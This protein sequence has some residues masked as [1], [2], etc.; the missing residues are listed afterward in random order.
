[1][2]TMGLVAV[3]KGSEDIQFP[4]EAWL[5]PVFAQTIRKIEQGYINE[6]KLDPANRTKE[7]DRI[8]W[9]GQEKNS[10]LKV[11]VANCEEEKEQKEVSSIAPGA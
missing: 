11:R 9:V 7:G 6:G 8:E 10:T 5:A 2:S 1:M 3:Q 4:G